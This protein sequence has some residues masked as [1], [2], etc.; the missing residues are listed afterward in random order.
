MRQTLVGLTAGG[1][2]PHAVM[3][4][5]PK[6]SGRGRLA[7][8]LAAW[9]LCEGEQPPCGACLPCR[10]VL[11]GVHPDLQVFAGDGRAQGF[12]IEVVRALRESAYIA[13]NEGRCKVYLL[14]DVQEMTPAAQNAL[15]KTLEEP[16]AHLRFILT[17]TNRALVLETIRSRVTT[18]ALPLLPPEAYG[19]QLAEAFPQAGEAQR[20]AAAVCAGSL[21]GARQLLEQQGE[22]VQ[23][24]VQLLEALFGGEHELLCLLPQEDKQREELLQLAAL[25]E[26]LLG[27]L[28]VQKAKGLP[29]PGFERPLSRL[30]TGQMAALCRVLR[31]CSALAA[32]NVNVALLGA[33]LSGALREA[34]SQ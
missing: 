25:L 31:Q 4:E 12:H 15:L 7:R 16:P 5:G 24:A 20:L 6:G 9:A 11:G 32:G 33:W 17:V 14:Q 10:K 29:A 23:T 30:T 8:A 13:P 19:A 3:L 18:V 22:T 1:R 21:A 34:L 27:W 2:L 26:G 28:L